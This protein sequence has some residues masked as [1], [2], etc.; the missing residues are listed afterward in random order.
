MDT[1]RD[2]AIE[3]VLNALRDAAPPEGMQLRIAQRLEQA[4]VERQ[5]AQLQAA[6]AAG[7]LLGWLDRVA[8]PAPSAA[9]WHGA[10]CGAAA[11]ALVMG[12]AML[13][14]HGAPARTAQGQSQSQ[15]VLREGDP[16]LHAPVS[17]KPVSAPAGPC[18]G[19]E[20]ARTKRYLPAQKD[21][22]AVGADRARPLADAPLT[23]EERDLVRLARVADPQDLRTLNPEAQAKSE[24]EE[25][26]EFE[27]F[28]PPPPPPPAAEDN[29]GNEL[30][31]T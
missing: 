6:G 22:R 31:G 13:V 16:G 25:T 9:W 28:F 26:T 14:Q 29:Q 17:G 20:L 3:R 12:A 30:P 8:W 10:V 19:L 2:D 7:P 21:E 11:A 23:A 4:A 18:T 15:R 5:A 24:A 1:E 27:S